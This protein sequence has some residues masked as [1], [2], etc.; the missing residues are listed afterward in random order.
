MEKQTQ[1]GEVVWPTSQGRLEG[2]DQA[3][4]PFQ[5]SARTLEGRPAPNTALVQ[6]GHPTSQEW[7]TWEQNQTT[8]KKI[9]TDTAGKCNTDTFTSHA[10]IPY[11]LETQDS[12]AEVHCG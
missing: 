6:D 4:A 3:Q 9:K 5:T 12:L 1:G 2:G 7:R 11:L 10:V 8:G